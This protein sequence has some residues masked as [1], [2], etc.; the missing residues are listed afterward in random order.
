MAPEKCHRCGSTRL[1]DGIVKSGRSLLFVPNDMTFWNLSLGVELDA[2]LCM[3]CGAV[4]LFGDPEKAEKLVP[5][6]KSA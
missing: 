6:D 3:V 5:H 1:V 2:Y 4:E